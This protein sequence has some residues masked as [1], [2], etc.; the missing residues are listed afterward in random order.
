MYFQN[1][2]LILANLLII[3]LILDLLIIFSMK[4]F[5]ISNM[6]PS[7]KDQLFGVFVKNFKL[8]LERQNVIFSEESLIKGR[9]I[10]LVKKTEKYILHYLSIIKNF[11]F[12]SYDIIYIHYLAHHIPI[13]LLLLPFKRKKW[14][15]NTHGNDVLSIEKNSLLKKI[16][17][18][19][20]KN[21]DLIIVPSSYFEKVLLDNYNFLKKEDIFISPSGGIDTTIFHPKE[22]TKLFKE[23]IHLGFVS[24][25]IR[26]KGWKTFLEALVLLKNN[27]ISFSAT[28]AGKGPDEE[29]IKK[30]I[31][32]N[33]LT[34]IN[35]LGFVEQR[36]LADLY[37][38]F[39]LY[40]FPTL[41]DS[42]GLTGLEAMACGTPVVST[43]S[44]GPST[45]IQSEINGYLFEPKD[46]SQLTSCIK[47]FFNL[48]KF[49]KNLMSQKALE[50]ANYYE[51][52]LV[53]KKLIE[54]LRILISI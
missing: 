36:S 10:S 21:I 50:T 8:E 39:D 51:K 27:N 9:S 22:N 54:R 52:N 14:V 47:K 26:E 11:I 4:I 33:N 23:K 49:D 32:N 46:D 20:L 38:Q 13:L 42:L 44:T 19:L 15:I 35:F 37:S 30:F 34:E 25:F 45:Y 1:K 17:N 41:S 29:E 3:V 53:T 2:T 48:N 24:R 12:G 6:F 5:L 28:I 43:N 7:K 16:S 31:R 40:I 18:V